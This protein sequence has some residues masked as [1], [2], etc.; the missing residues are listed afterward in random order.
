VAGKG[1]YH[2][3]EEGE[4]KEGVVILRD[5]FA[6]VVKERITATADTGEG[7]RIGSF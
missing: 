3:G 1:F 6:F 2:K 4:E 5:L 7:A